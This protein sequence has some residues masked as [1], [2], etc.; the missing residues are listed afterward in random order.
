M[1]TNQSPKELPPPEAVQTLKAEGDLPVLPLQFIQVT[2]YTTF[3][4]ELAIT[5]GDIVFH[6]Y[7]TEE[8]KQLQK[9]TP[10]EYWLG[11][12]G[13]FPNAL[14][15]VAQQHF[16]VGYPRLKASYTEEMASWWL[17]A[18]GFGLLLESHKFAYAFL[19]RLDAALDAAISKAV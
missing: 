1:M 5:D 7:V 2:E 14:S 10:R 4:A 16:E 19:E 11:D 17:R 8:V 9:P 6:F 3:R 12:N 15:E 18:Y 13:I